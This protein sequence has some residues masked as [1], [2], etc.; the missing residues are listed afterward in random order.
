[1]ACAAAPARPR[2]IGGRWPER[3]QAGRIP[4]TAGVNWGASTFGDR[5][6]RAKARQVSA[7]PTRCL[8]VG[9]FGRLNRTTTLTRDLLILSPHIPECCPPS[10][11][12]PTVVTYSCSRLRPKW[13]QILSFSLR[14]LL[15]PAVMI[16]ALR[17][18]PSPRLSGGAAPV[19]QAQLPP[20]SRCVSPWVHQLSCAT[21]TKQ[22]GSVVWRGRRALP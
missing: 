19:W 7:R 5:A 22:W 16:R 11:S 17:P 4:R 15:W 14:E 2:P 8:V 21:R 3:R 13:T 12:S 1:M 9:R 10:A 20:P 18:S 6:A